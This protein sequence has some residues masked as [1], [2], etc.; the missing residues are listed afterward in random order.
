[1]SS[2]VPAPVPAPDDDVERLIASL[3]RAQLAAGYPVNEVNDTL[4][5]VARAYDRPD[6]QIYV[7]PNA[8][9]VDNETNGRAR[10]VAGDIGTLRL[11]QAAEVHRVARNASIAAIP[12]A[13]ATKRLEE[14]NHLKPR[15]SAVTVVVANGFTAA[16]FALVFRVSLWGVL[17]AGILGVFVAIALRLTA[18]RPGLSAIMPFFAAAVAAYVVFTIGNIFDEQVQPI[19]VVAAPLITLIPGVG[20]TR[21]TQELANGQLISGSSRLVNAIMQILVLT[22]GVLVG[23]RL[24]PIDDYTFGDLTDVLLPWWAA[25]IGVLVFAVGQSMVSNEARGGI[26]IV[27]GLLIVAYGIQS[28]VAATIDPV[29]AAGLAAAA[30]LFLAILYQRRSR[31]GMPAFALFEPVFWLLVPGSLGLV[32]LTEVFA[33]RDQALP[34]PESSDSSVFSLGA[35]T[36]VLFVAAATIIAITIGM[37]M[38]S[39]LGRLIPSVLPK[40]AEVA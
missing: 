7:L 26:R 35:G 16:G 23:A 20:L 29:L 14:I 21:G 10:I 27:V 38:A 39:A 1:M 25:W 37:V 3:G 17:I 31:Q 36:D 30:T 33:G 6:L 12:P 15:F 40:A 19:R 8:V 22:F 13:A 24:A 9:F 2:S 4:A 28:L 11:D 32:A 18:S 34:G 5:A